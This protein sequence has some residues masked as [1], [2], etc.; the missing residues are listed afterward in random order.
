MSI[1]K[2]VFI[3][4]YRDRDQQY[5][6]FKRHMQYI[7]EDLNKDEYRIYYIH[8][9]DE[10]DFNRGALKNI[11]FLYVKQTWPE[12]YQSITLVFN[13][14]DTM[15]YT[16]NFLNYETKP[17]FVK[18][19]YGFK[20]ALGGIVSI[21][22]MDFEKV[23]GFPNFWA[24]GYEDNALNTRVKKA[25]LVIDRTQFYPLMDKN[26][27]QLNDGVHRSV[28]RKEFDRYI[29]ETGEGYHSIQNL[30]YN[31][32]EET[33]FVNVVFFTTPF[34]SNA[35]ENTTYDLRKGPSPFKPNSVIRRGA[36]AFT[37]L[38]MAF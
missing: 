19:F 10:R 11:G 31:V 24:W 9:Q 17:G 29:N 36:R 7:L 33:G 21:N 12:N 16:K 25:E 14:L 18:H 4:P 6:F 37:S 35:K 30:K 8:Q 34:E 15:P 38:K 32:N 5:H 2:I 27:L 28:N 23:G 13:D 1:P 22:A 26:I 3:V 20:Y